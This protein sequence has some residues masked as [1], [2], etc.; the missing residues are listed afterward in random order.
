MEITIP[1]G[2]K[3]DRAAEYSARRQRTFVRLNF[4]EKLHFSCVRKLLKVKILIRYLHLSGRNFLTA[5]VD[6]FAH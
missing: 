2:S 1:V 3:N 5:L 4:Y 6:H